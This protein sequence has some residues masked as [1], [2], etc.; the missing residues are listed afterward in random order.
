MPTPGA[1]KLAPPR[2]AVKVKRWASGRPLDTV[3]DAELRSRMCTPKKAYD[4]QEAADIARDQLAR[5]TDA[6]K[7]KVYRCPYCGRFHVGTRHRSATESLR[8]D[9][10][11]RR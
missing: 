6:K 1:V 4:T 3:A 9:S 7:P 11:A 2:A 10:P 5:T 8:S